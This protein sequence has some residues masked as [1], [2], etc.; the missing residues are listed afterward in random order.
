M[1]GFRGIVA[2]IAGI[3]CLG[4]SGCAP[5]VYVPIGEYGDGYRMAHHGVVVERD[6]ATVRLWH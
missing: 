2:V 1:L 4:A 6:V 3:A 5:V